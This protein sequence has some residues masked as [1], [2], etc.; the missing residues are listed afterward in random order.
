M[1]TSAELQAELDSYRAARDKILTGAQ[2]YRLGNVNLSRADLAEIHS[3]IKQLEARLAIVQAGGR[4]GGS[5]V[6]FGGHRG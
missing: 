5:A 1:A 6:V 4:V 2:N 3:R